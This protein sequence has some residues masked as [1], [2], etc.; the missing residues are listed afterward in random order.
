MLK[1][2]MGACGHE[3]SSFGI[4]LTFREYYPSTLPGDDKVHALYDIKRR[5]GPAMCTYL[6]FGMTMMKAYTDLLP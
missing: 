3:H 1:R 2:K 4:T 6:S 5:M